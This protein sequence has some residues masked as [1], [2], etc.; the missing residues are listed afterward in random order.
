[1]LPARGRR[2]GCPKRIFRE[3]EK[4]L[5]LHARRRSPFSFTVSDMLP[6]YANPISLSVFRGDQ[7]G[8]IIAWPWILTIAQLSISGKPMQA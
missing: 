5:R 8:T 7:A 2:C 3:R 1:M 4:C 6:S